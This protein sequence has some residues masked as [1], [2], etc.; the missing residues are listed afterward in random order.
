M[1][2][3]KTPQPRALSSFD[4]LDAAGIGAGYVSPFTPGA[5]PAADEPPKSRGLMSVANDTVIEA[6]NAAAGGLSSAANFIKP[7]NAVSGW[8]DKNIIQAGEE[9]Q[10]D[11][12]K[13]SKKKFREGVANADGV[14]G[15]L[16]AWAPRASSVLAGP[17]VLLLALPWRAVM[18]PVPL[19]SWL[20]RR[21]QRRKRQRLLHAKPA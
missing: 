3:K 21:G 10:S 9:S 15:E 8:I 16:L 18:L 5:A 19:M 17:V 1:A 6:A 11:V 2:K 7:G 4:D 12:V 13:A 14:M 20:S